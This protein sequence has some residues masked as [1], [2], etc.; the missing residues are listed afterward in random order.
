MA[1]QQPLQPSIA[2]LGAKFGEL[3]AQAYAQIITLEKQ[4]T[5]HALT[6]QQLVKNEAALVDHI[7]KL[8]GEREGGRTTMSPAAH[9]IAM[10]GKETISATKKPLESG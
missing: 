4:L 10:Q 8:E 3:L 2:E 6:I 7:Q 1:D 9:S 5:A